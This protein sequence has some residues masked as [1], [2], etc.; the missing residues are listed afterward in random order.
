MRRATPAEQDLR[1]HDR[2]GREP[3]PRPGAVRPLERMNSPLESRK[4]R[5]R[6][7]G[8][9]AVCGVSR[10]CVSATVR[11]VLTRAGEAR[12]GERERAETGLMAVPAAGFSPW[13]PRGV[14]RDPVLRSGTP[15]GPGASRLRLR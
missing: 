12:F 1:I 5:L 3:I 10:T 15:S 2:S 9:L 6:G 8:G 7:L 13:R 11:A 14:P 4:V